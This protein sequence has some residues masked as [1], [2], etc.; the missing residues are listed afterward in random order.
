MS[1]RP[2]ALIHVQHLL[3][4]G[5]L[6]RA[7]ALGRGLAQA[8]ASVTVASGGMPVPNLPVGGMEF[9][10]LPPVRAADA[11]FKQLLDETGRPV[12]D[13]WRAR[14]RDALVG[15]FARV[16]PDLLVIELYPF[17]RRLLRFELEPLL[18]A[19]RARR[20]R[21]VVA[22]SLR[23]IIHPPAPGR[24][25]PIVAAVRERFDLVLVHG[26]PDLIPLD[27]SFP[28]VGRIAA[29]LHYTGYLLDQPAPAAGAGAARE[30]EVIVSSGGGAVGEPLLK[31]A[32][33]A[34]PLTRHRGRPW[35]LLAGHNLDEAAFQ[36]LRAAASQGVVVE[37]ARPDFTA[38]LPGVLCS[39]SQAGYNTAVEVLAARAPAVFVP[40]ADEAEVEQT[41]R[42]RA[43]ARLALCRWVAPGE[44]G[45]KTLAQAI[46]AA[47]AAPEGLRIDTDGA[48]NSATVL[49]RVVAEKATFA[50]DLSQRRDP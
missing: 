33:Q 5:H 22:C 26:D 23:D 16:R 19:A 43:L 41:M 10:Q 2:R 44:L 29:K 37:R 21:P 34:R 3:G 13:A 7:L 48:R 14:R 17:G 27:L 24:I 28:E 49:L 20:P 47:E 50:G 45:P 1:A 6:R 46:D 42:C 40:F 36:S 30:P 15:L 18:D 8:G 32:L 35:R 31:A 25:E 38:L 9:V 4:V 11:T 39:V 12:D